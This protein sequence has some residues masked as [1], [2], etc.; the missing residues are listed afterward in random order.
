M[1]SDWTRHTALF[2]C[3]LSL[4]TFGGCLSSCS[5][6]R[7]VPRVESMSD[8]EFAVWKQRTVMQVGAVTDE[9]VRQGDLGP[10]QAEQIA[11]AFDSAAFT[12]SGLTSLASYVDAEGYDALVLTI[13]LSELDAEL[14]R[15]G[16]LGGEFLSERARGLL[17]DLGARVRK[18][19]AMEIK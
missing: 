4:A 3:A 8:S 19:A 6:V 12:S 5:T 18:S 11:D 15:R 14:Y 17:V 10:A 16:V 9:L 13:M 2:V 7:D 1:K